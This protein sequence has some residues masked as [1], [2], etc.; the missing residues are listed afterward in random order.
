MDRKKPIMCDVAGMFLYNY[1]EAQ[2]A[3]DELRIIR[4]YMIKRGPD[5]RG[6][7]FSEDVQVGLGHGFGSA[8]KPACGQRG[9]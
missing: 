5:G 9:G 6:E 8:S 3:C 4:D 7:R 2:V 1:F